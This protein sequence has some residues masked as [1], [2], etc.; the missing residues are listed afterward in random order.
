MTAFFVGVVI[1]IILSLSNKFIR[2]LEPDYPEDNNDG[3]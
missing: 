2:L 1:G 3:N